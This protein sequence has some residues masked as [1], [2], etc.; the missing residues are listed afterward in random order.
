[1]SGFGQGL[2]LV[3][4]ALHLLEPNGQIFTLLSLVLFDLQVFFCPGVLFFLFGMR[5]FR[6]RIPNLELFVLF[7]AAIQVLKHIPQ[8]FGQHGLLQATLIAGLCIGLGLKQCK[9]PE[10]LVKLGKKFV[11]LFGRAQ[12]RFLLAQKLLDFFLLLLLFSLLD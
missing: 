9:C 2:G 5:F 6:N 11:H 1:M 7:P 12:K 4:Q 8:A 3:L 10:R